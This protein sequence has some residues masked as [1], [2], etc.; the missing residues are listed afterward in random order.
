[1]MD[2]PLT[3][4]CYQRNTSHPLFPPSVT[5]SLPCFTLVL[6]YFIPP[7]HLNID[8][9]SLDSPK[10][11]MASSFSWTSFFKV[12]HQALYVLV[13]LHLQSSTKLS[14]CVKLSFV[15][16]VL[17]CLLHLTAYCCRHYCL[18]SK[19]LYLHTPSF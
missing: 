3:M 8:L 17:F 15:Y 12:P 13:T 18:C 19:I 2:T 11:E 7:Q 16:Q 6:I 5:S 4:F 1:M 14:C 9:P 10:G